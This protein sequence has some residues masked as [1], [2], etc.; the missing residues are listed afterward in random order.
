[1]SDLTRGL[2]P[3]YDV[4]RLHDSVGKHD[5]CWFFV[6]DPEHDPI[7]RVALAA[8]ADEARRQGYTALADDLEAKQ[9]T[10]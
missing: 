8:Y 6:L 2:Y 10:S 9:E 5:A 7:A 3:K 4:K 1:M